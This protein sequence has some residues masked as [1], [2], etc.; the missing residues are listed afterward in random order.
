MAS[1]LGPG[2]LETKNFLIMSSDNSYKKFQTYSFCG[3]CAI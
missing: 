2:G 3:L 1:S